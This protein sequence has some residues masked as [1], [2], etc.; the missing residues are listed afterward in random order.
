MQTTFED[1]GSAL[2][3]A[4]DHRARGQWVFLREMYEDMDGTSPSSPEL[5]VLL[6][7]AQLRV[8]EPRVAQRLLEEVIP[9]FERRGDSTAHCQALNML[10]AAHFEAGDLADAEEAFSRVMEL[11]LARGND[12]LVA[13]ATN[14]LGSIANIRK[15]HEIALG[16]YQLAVPAFQ[17][18][19]NIAGLAETHHNMAIAYRDL[20]QLG[21]A[22]RSERRAIEFAREAEDRRLLAMARVGR[23]ELNLLNGQAEVA[24][25]GA[26]MAANECRDIPDPVGEADALRLVGAARLALGALH[27]AQAAVDRA[28]MLARKHGNTLVEAEALQT[29]ARIF[30]RIGD[31]R[32]ARTD[33]QLAINLY[34]R[35]D[36]LAEQQA[37]EQWMREELD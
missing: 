12:L 9:I 32:Q 16:L 8:G 1:P 28:V 2:T 11:A 24:H 31:R 13:R 6:A 26:R 18:T 33:A 21:Q 34:G 5:A 19:G 3:R 20:R 29:R 15:R 30:A 22:E 27:E 14:N 7:E 37:L 4:R 36:T 10:G 35:L 25:A 23:A 17:R